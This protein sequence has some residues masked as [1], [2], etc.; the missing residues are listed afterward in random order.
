M[1]GILATAN[2][3]RLNAYIR[4]T[5]PRDAAQE[6]CN[7][8]TITVLRSWV[9]ARRNRDG[10]MSA[11][12]DATIAVLDRVIAGDPFNPDEVRAWRDAVAADRQVRVDVADLF[13]N[14]PLPNC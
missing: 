5:A 13:E 3:F 7:T 4:E 11:R 10:A 14:H 6:A 1:V 8:E 12:D 2:T 9:E